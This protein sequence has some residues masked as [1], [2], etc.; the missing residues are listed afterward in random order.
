[1]LGEALGGGHSQNKWPAQ[2]GG[3]DPYSDNGLPKAFTVPKA[4]LLNISEHSKAHFRQGSRVQFH[5][6]QFRLI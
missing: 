4:Q 3:R 6:N 2:C 5:R 1:M